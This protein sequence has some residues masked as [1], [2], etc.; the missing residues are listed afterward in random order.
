[1]KDA[2][3]CSLPIVGIRSVMTT[4]TLMMHTL[5]VGIWGILGL[6]QL[7]EMLS[8]EKER[9]RSSWRMLAAQ[10]LDS[11]PSIAVIMGCL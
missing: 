3:K 6:L 11:H 5:Y 10:D 1:M 4:G 2:L 9:E 8:M 7:L